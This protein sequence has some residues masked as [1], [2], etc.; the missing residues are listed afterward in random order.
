MP[1]GRGAKNVVYEE[2]GK[3]K[4]S[5]MAGKKKKGMHK[6]PGGEKMK[7]SEMDEHMARGRKMRAA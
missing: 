1:L 3:P 5:S 2:M 6:M 7:D 4:Y